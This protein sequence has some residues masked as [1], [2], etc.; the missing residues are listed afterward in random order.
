ME[1]LQYLSSLPAGL[2]SH[3][4]E[5]ATIFVTITAKKIIYPKYCQI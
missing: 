1:I 4:N 2:E 5:K 3:L